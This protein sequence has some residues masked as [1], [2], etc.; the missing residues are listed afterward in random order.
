MKEAVIAKLQSGRP[1]QLTPE[2][3]ALV[4]EALRDAVATTLELPREEIADGSR[5]FADLG[6]DSI[7]VFDVLDQLSERFEVPVA[8]EELP[9]TILRGDAETTFRAFAE[10]LL[11]YFREAPAPPAGSPNYVMNMGSNSLNLFKCHVDF[12]N[13]NNSTLTGPINIPVAA[14]SSAC[15]GGNCI[16]Q[17]GTNK[18]VYALA[19]RLM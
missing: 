12:N 10:A 9:E 11:R 8:L 3:T 6:L 4:V 1:V 16:P 17:P 2:E 15:G 7:D 5:V 18:P 19:D 13:I 14:F